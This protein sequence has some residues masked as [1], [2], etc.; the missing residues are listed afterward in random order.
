MSKISKSDGKRVLQSLRRY[1]ECTICCEYIGSDIMQC[2][3]GHIVCQ[4]CRSKMQS[5]VCPYCKTTGPWSKNLALNG[6]LDSFEIRCPNK[7]C[8][9]RCKRAKFVDHAKDCQYR[10]HK[11]HCGELV[12]CNSNAIAEHLKV[13]H[14]AFETSA[15]GNSALVNFALPSTS[16]HRIR[17][18]W[19]PHV[20]HFPKGSFVLFA[21]IDHDTFCVTVLSLEDRRDSA[22]CQLTLTMET[23]YKSKI[24][25][26][27]PCPR[28]IYSGERKDY[29]L[30]VSKRTTRAENERGDK[31]YGI[32]VGV[33]G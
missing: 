27:I 21:L 33:G 24:V 17:L 23:V 16:E 14:K 28:Y 32:L 15:V 9:F 8:K 11:C 10:P 6:L 4:S 12:I 26:V 5:D 7:P 31:E 30:I 13:R 29:D 20:L 1:L 19:R 3:N 25:T 18:V 2:K 22:A